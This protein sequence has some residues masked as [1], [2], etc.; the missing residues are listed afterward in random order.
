MSFARRIYSIQIAFDSLLLFE[1]VTLHELRIR[2]TLSAARTCSSSLLHELHAHTKNT[3]TH[4]SDRG[5]LD[6]EFGF[7]CFCMSVEDLQ[8]QIDTIPC[9]H[10]QFCFS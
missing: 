5:E 7:R 2:F 6:L 1:K 4:V 8:N 3:W 10:V 9:L